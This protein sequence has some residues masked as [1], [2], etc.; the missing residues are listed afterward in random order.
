MKGASLYGGR[1][2]RDVPAYTAAEAALLARVPVSTL[3]SWVFGRSIVVRDGTRRVSGIIK[4]PDKRFLSF[5]NV[6]EAHVLAALR[7]EHEIDLPKIRK[8][9]SYVERVLQVP[10]PLAHERFKTDGVDLFVEYFGKLIAVS[11][12][13]QLAIREVI[14]GHLAR[15]EYETDRAIRLFPLRRPDAPRVVVIDPRLAFGRPVIEGT[16]V[17]V[18]D[19][20]SRFNAGDDVEELAKDYRLPEDVVQEALRD[21]KNAAA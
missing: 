5:T 7:R 19:I 14:D 13:G 2:P 21:P 3:R 16:A 4:A 1:D 10:H 12:D 8:A 15:V 20:R 6:V 11:Q 17:P 9:V 18:A